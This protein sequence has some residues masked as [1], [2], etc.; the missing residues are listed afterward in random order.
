MPFN[1]GAA[2]QLTTEGGMNP[3]ESP[4][5]RY[6]YYATRGSET[7]LWKLP[8]TGGPAVR[9]TNDLHQV[10]GL[11]AVNDGAYYVARPAKPGNLQEFR[12]RFIDANTRVSRDVATV[13]GPLGWG[14]SVS[15]DRQKLL[16]VRTVPGRFDLK[17]ARP[18][19]Q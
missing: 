14:L 5:G 2:V 3:R 13:A 15:A 6:L 7:A 9:L 17:V 16:F 8:L 11:H 12:I 1:R 4:D 10:I 18:A 19:A